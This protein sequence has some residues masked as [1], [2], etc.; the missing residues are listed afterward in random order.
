MPTCRHA[1]MPACNMQPRTARAPPRASCHRR[2]AR[3]RSSGAHRDR[4]KRRDGRERWRGVRLFGARLPACGSGPS[5]L[6]RFSLRASSSPHYH[7][8]PTNSHAAPSHASPPQPL[9]PPRP[10]PCPH[11]RAGLPLRAT[12]STSTT[13][14]C[15]PSTPRARSSRAAPAPPA[16]ASRRAPPRTP[17]HCPRRGTSTRQLAPSPFF[18]AL[19]TRACAPPDPPTNHPVYGAA[20]FVFEMQLSDRE[21]LSEPPPPSKPRPAASEDAGRPRSARLG[22]STR[23]RVE[24]VRRGMLAGAREHTRRRK[25]TP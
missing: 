16:C 4:H 19:L 17:L 11:A 5:A 12:R 21:L 6:V 14:L 18:P 13:S 22:E 2:R 3:R 23:G 9:Q 10:L 24:Q 8:T 1:D 7:H 20:Q 25:Q 15:C